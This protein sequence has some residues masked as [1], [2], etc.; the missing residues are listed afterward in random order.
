MTVLENDN[1]EIELN[2][3]RFPRTFRKAIN[4]LFAEYEMM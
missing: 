2:D 4:Q 3:K 1:F